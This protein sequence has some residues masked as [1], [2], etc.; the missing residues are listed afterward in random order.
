V[1]PLALRSHFVHRPLIFIWDATTEG[2]YGTQYRLAIVDRNGRTLNEWRYNSG[3]TAGFASPDVDETVVM[4]GLPRM[5]GGLWRLQGWFN[6]GQ[7]IPASSEAVM[8][9]PHIITP[10]YAADC[11]ITVAVLIV[12]ATVAILVVNR[13][14]RPSRRAVLREKVEDKLFCISCSVQ[15]PPD[16]K[17]CNK[18]ASAQS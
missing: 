1:N 10:R 12:I 3:A 7:P 15:L 14:R 13:T 18:C 4:E 16:S 2:V 9:E 8:N 5:V 11:T 17:F 6:N